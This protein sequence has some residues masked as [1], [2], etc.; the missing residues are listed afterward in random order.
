MEG[1]EQMAATRII[2]IDG[3]DWQVPVEHDEK[4]VRES[5]VQAGFPNANN[6]DIQKS[7]TTIEGEEFEVWE[8]Q[9]PKNLYRL[10]KF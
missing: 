3:N 10:E 8:F 6:A 1:M 4:T 9:L 7:T 5:L 2:K